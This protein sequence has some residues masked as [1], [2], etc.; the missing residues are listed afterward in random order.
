MC[1]YPIK[2]YIFLLFQFLWEERRRRWIVFGR[3]WTT[4]MQSAADGWYGVKQNKTACLIILIND[5]IDGMHSASGYACMI[6]GSPACYPFSV[7]GKCYGFVWPS[8]SHQIYLGISKKITQVDLHFS[9]CVT[10]K[11]RHE[12]ESGRRREGER[13]SMAGLHFPA[14]ITEN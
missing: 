3:G 12:P 7:I 11:I 4:M 10:L 2:Q 5:L 14:C 13:E 1:F 9:S 8:N 6:Q